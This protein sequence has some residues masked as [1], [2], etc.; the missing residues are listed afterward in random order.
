MIALGNW[1]GLETLETFIEKKTF[2][3]DC[4]AVFLKPLK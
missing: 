4:G 2:W 1:A 3:G